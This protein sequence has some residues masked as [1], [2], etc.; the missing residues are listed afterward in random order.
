MARLAADDEWTSGT[1]GGVPERE[2]WRTRIVE[3]GREFGGDATWAAQ[4]CATSG[5]RVWRHPWCGR[6]RWAAGKC[7]R[8]ERVLVGHGVPDVPVRPRTTCARADQSVSELLGGIVPGVCRSLSKFT[9][10]DVPSTHARVTGASS[11]A[12][13]VTNSPKLSLAVSSG[14]ACAGLRGALFKSASSAV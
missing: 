6:G 13:A 11:F 1:L 9:F 5:T 12:A 3:V 8:S 2:R 4:R 10:S 14:A 7:E